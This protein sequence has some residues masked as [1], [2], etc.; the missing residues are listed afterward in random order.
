MIKINSKEWWQEYFVEKRWEQNGGNAQTFFFANILLE[1]ID[2]HFL[3]DINKNKYSVCDFGC[4]C[5]ELTKLL[6]DK[7]FNCDVYGLDVSSAAVQEAKK[8]FPGVEFK[9]KDILE[10]S[11]YIDTIF[12]SN[13]LEHFENPYDILRRLLNISR[14]YLI[15]MVPYR[16]KNLD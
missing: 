16:E 3:E 13:V 10:S 4:A 8:L 12:C 7:L 1:N 15:I 2:L 9:Q 11:E 14:K 6:H 5:G